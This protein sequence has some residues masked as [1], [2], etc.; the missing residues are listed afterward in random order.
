MGI[1]P[2]PK[3][4]RHG[5]ARQGRVKTGQGREAETPSLFGTWKCLFGGGGVR[6]G[7]CIMKALSRAGR[8]PKIRIGDASGVAS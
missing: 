2:P 3:A 8:E 6:Y 5:R 7:D 4:Q 1:L